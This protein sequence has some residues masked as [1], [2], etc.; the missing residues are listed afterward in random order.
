MAVPTSIDNLDYLKEDAQ[1]LCGIDD[2]DEQALALLG[3]YLMKRC[4]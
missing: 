2:A 1:F 3:L 4:R